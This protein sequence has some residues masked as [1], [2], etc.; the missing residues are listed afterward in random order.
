MDSLAIVKELNVTIYLVVR[1]LLRSKSLAINEFLLE[2]TVKGFY[3]RIV[4]AVA[5]SAH[6]S[7]HLVG[8]ELLPVVIRCILAPAIGMVEESFLR[9]L[10]RIGV[11]KSTKDKIRRHSVIQAPTYDLTGA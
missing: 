8:F 9:L 2:D 3:A 10:G 5:F 7:L 6:A 1:L 4:V 11:L